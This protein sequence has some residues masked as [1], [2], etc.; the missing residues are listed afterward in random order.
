MLWSIVIRLRGWSLKDLLVALGAGEVV[1]QM[2]VRGRDWYVLSEMVALSWRHASYNCHCYLYSHN[3]VFRGPDV[4]A[5]T[6]FLHTIHLV[7]INY[8]CSSSSVS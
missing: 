1:P 7:G 3:L 8:S 5:C 4:F 2:V 6:A